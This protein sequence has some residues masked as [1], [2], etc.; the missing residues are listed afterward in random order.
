VKARRILSLCF[1]AAGAACPQAAPRQVTADKQ[2]ASVY[3]IQGKIQRQT[4]TTSAASVMVRLLPRVLNARQPLSPSAGG[5][6]MAGPDGSFELRN[7]SSGSYYLAAMRMAGRVET[8][9][10]IAVD[11]KDS[12]LRDVILPVADALVVTGTVQVEGNRRASLGHGRIVLRPAA[13]P[14]L[15]ASSAAVNTDRNFKIEGVVPE[16]YLI[17]FTGFPDNFYPKSARMGDS[18]LLDQGLDLTGA[19]Q[20]VTLAVTLSTNGAAVLGTLNDGG[21]PVR[22]AWLVLVPDPYRPESLYRVKTGQ[23]DRNGRCTIEGLVPGDY[24]VYALGSLEP[25]MLLDPGTVLKPLE[26]S[27]GRVSVSEGSRVHVEMTVLRPEGIRPR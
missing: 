9:G 23:S 18:E 20:P 1:I 24:R 8:I 27:A 10:R 7:V 13:S 16:K 3:R 15:E 11:V 14:L 2:S 17:L 25:D 5:S 12:D 22:G 21:K 19:P 4:P 6:A 26:E